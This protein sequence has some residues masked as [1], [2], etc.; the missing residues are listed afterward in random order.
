M[1]VHKPPIQCLLGLFCASVS[2]DIRPLPGAWVAKS[3]RVTIRGPGLIKGQNVEY[4]R[5]WH[6]RALKC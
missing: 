5:H 3:L 6:F 4:A 2:V 1:G